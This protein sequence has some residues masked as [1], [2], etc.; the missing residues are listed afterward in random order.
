MSTVTA[1]ALL[2]R[3]SFLE[4]LSEALHEVEDGAG[5]LV[6]IAGEAGV[7][8]TALIRRFCADASGSTRILE[9]ACDA[10]FTPRPFAPIA[11]SPPRQ[12]AR[13]RS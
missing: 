9:G 11:E 5:R 3:E 12:A 7:G 2:E 4:A 1:G 8:K 6:L 13:L 10:L